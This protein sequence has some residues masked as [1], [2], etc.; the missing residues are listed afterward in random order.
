MMFDRRNFTSSSSRRRGSTPASS[1]SRRRGSMPFVFALVAFLLSACTSY[2]EEFEDEY[3]YGKSSKGYELNGTTLTD[4]RDEHTY[5]VAKVGNLYWMLDNVAY[6]F[7]RNHDEE[8]KADCPR[9]SETTC[10][11]TGFLYPGTKLDYVCPNGWRLPSYEEWEEFSNSSAFLNYTLDNDVYKGYMSGDRSLNKD[12]EA[13]YFWTN[14]ADGSH[15]RKCLSITPERGSFQIAGPCHEQWKLAVR[16]VLEVN[17]G[18]SQSGDSGNDEPVD[19]HYLLNQYNCS[20]S[21][22]VKVLYPEGGESFK[23]GETIPVIYG[24]D[25]KGSGYRFV[26][27]TSEDDA[28]VDLLE[29]SAGEENPNGQSCYVQEVKLSADI[30]GDASTGI[31]RVVPYEN[32]S[33]G[34]NSGA[35][36]IS[37]NGS[38][39]PSSDSE[40]EGRTVKLEDS[41]DGQEYKAVI[42]GGRAWMVENLRYEA[43]PSYCLGSDDCDVGMLYTWDVAMQACPDGWHLPSIEEWK[44]FFIAEAGREQAERMRDNAPFGNACTLTGSDVSAANISVSV[45]PSAYTDT[46]RCKSSSNYKDCGEFFVKVENNDA[47][48]YTDLELHFYIALPGNEVSEMPESNIISSYSPSGETLSAPQ[49]TFGQYTEDNTGRPYLPIFI[50]GM[51]PPSGGKII[52]QLLWHNTTFNRLQGGWSLVEHAGDDYIAPFNGIDLTVAPHSTGNETDETYYTVDPYIPVYMYEQLV[53]GIPPEGSEVGQTATRD[54]VPVSDS[55]GLYYWTSDEVDSEE[56][57][58]LYVSADSGIEDDYPLS[59]KGDAAMLVRCVKD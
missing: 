38:S 40:N 55:Y 4:L 10:K 47:I 44:S 57:Y 32:S 35:F 13:A 17:G 54:C 14:E 1:S 12:G 53:S 20:V 36:K 39:S 27:K 45:K 41:R 50:N 30:V 58:H 46:E 9:P 15:Y 7:Y 8:D 31:I 33:K 56:A 21:D 49:V 43:S 5:N 3:G 18:S 59:S 11:N 23:V 16:C 19:Y 25:V 22:G 29:E 42:I 24:S 51:L 28:G 6:K 52:F 37:N 48:G 26:F 34:A 2:Y